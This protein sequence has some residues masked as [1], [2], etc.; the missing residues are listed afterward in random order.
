MKNGQV[1]EVV[2][3]RSDDPRHAEAG[4]GR[5]PKQ[6]KQFTTTRVDDPKLTEELEASGVKYTGEIDQPL[7]ARAARLDHAAAL[8]RRHLGLLL[9][10]HGRRRRRR[11]VV[12]PQPR[13]DLR[14]RR[15][16]GAVHGRRRRRRSRGRA[17]GNRRV[18]EEPEEVHEPRRPDSEGRAAGRPAGHRQDA[19]RARGRRRGARAVLQPERIG[20]RRDVRRRRR[21]AHPR[22]VS[23]GRSE[24][25]LH[26]LHRRARR[27]RQ[28]ARAEPDRQP[29]GARA[30]A[31]PAA[32]RDGRLRLAQGRHHH[33]RH[34]PARSAR[35]GA[36]PPRPLR[37]AGARRQARRQGPR[38]DP[39]D[40][41]QGREDRARRRPEDRRGAHGRLRRRRSGQPRQ[42]SGAARGAQRQDRGRD[43]RTSSRRSIGS[44]AGPREEARDEHE[45]ARDR[46]VPRVGPRDRRHAC[47]P[48]LDPVHKISIVQ[49][50]FGA[51]GYTMQLP[52]EDRYL[53][54]RGDLLSQ[55]A[56]LLGGRTAEEIAL[57]EISTG[58]QN[59]LQ[60]A[61]DIARAMV[62]EFGMSD[63]LGAINYDGQQARALPRH[64]RC[65]RSAGS[66][67][68][69][70]RR[71]STPRS[72]AS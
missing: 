9:P 2:D 62:T 60:R 23:A 67:A 58:A 52:L 65:R 20:V 11:D 68:R 55:L 47:C 43:A 32:G 50:G 71:R 26:R 36:A 53:M 51:L 59:D 3:R 46:R 40:S 14:R 34:Q 69:R 15:S 41:R 45:G 13:E 42:R 66:T 1:A 16:E 39:A 18:P 56:V 35:P 33:G 5:R 27:A 7:A 19:A 63:A 48:D 30:D 44:I 24:G 31:E 10:A 57:G 12:R 54:T 29:R 64:R 6:S 4:G 70:R 28:G 8:L 72:S 61:T 17:E 37:S 49:R 22:S 25:A 21:R 38:G